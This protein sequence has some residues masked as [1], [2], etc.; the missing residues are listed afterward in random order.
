M[1]KDALVKRKE[2]HSKKTK[3]KPTSSSS[4]ALGIKTHASKDNDKKSKEEK[5][6][7]RK[8]NKQLL[9]ELG[10]MLVNLG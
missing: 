5:K 9:Q 10:E 4:Y 2:R 7:G 3:G 1:V 6:K 8:R